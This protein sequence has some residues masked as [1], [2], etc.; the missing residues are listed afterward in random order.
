MT[1]A[2]SIKTAQHAHQRLIELVQRYLAGDALKLLARLT[3]AGVFWRSLLTKVQTVGVF[4]YTE[5]INDF[6]VQRAYLR[7]PEFPLSLKASTLALFETEYALPLLPIEV[8]AWMATLAEFSLPILLV[9]GVMTRLSALALLG[10]TVV[11][12]IFVYPDA[13]WSTHALWVVMTAFV[14][15]SGPGRLSVDHWAGRY[16]AR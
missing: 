6:A 4:P 9:L 5:M 12:Q 14:A 11:I 10:M 16:F 8:A 1:I 7:L 15:G 13:W 2:A 3:L